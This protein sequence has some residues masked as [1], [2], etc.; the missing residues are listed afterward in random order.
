MKYLGVIILIAIA[1]TLFAKSWR[2]NN[3][4]DVQAD[5][6]TLADAHISASS[7]DTIYLEPS[8]KC[9]EGFTCTKKLV[10]I[11]AGYF[12]S[13]NSPTQSSPL[14]S[15]VC[16]DITFNPGSEGSEMMGISISNNT[17]N[18]KTSY[19]VIRR[20]LIKTIL[21]VYQTEV[22]LNNLFIT[23]NYIYNITGGVYLGHNY[24]IEGLVFSNNIVVNDF[25]FSYIKNKS[26]CPCYDQALYGQFTNNVFLGNVN[27]ESSTLRNNI[28][29]KSDFSPNLLKYN[30]YNTIEENI[31]AKVLPWSDV[32]NYQIP[33][34]NIDNANMG[35]LFVG[36]ASTDGKWQLQASNSIP[37]KDKCGAFNGLNPYVLSGIPDVP[38]IYYLNVPPIVNQKDGINVTIKAKSN[39]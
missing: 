20:N 8:L 10:L 22:T 9:Y 14:N 2:I 27:I 36:G 11:G 21:F 30:A 37:I 15:V 3:N 28:F 33:S 32:V 25:G 7:G 5:F 16:G 13:E 35:T 19:L 12:L 1:Q 17:V 26:D 31:F 34:S 29:Y 18:L 4:P 6:R 39:N 24:F 23:Q 38:T